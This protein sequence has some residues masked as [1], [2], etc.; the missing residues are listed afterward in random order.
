MKVTTAAGTW[1]LGND[2][3]AR[4]VTGGRQNANLRARI[5]KRDD[6]DNLTLLWDEAREDQNGKYSASYFHAVPVK[7]VR[8]LLGPDRD[9]ILA[10]L[11]EESLEE[12]LRRLEGSRNKLL[13][14]FGSLGSVMALIENGGTLDEIKK[15]LGDSMVYSIPE[16]ISASLRDTSY[17]AAGKI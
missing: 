10:N 4:D 16:D 5:D 3:I 12:K 8:E 15:A 6:G 13:A 1:E 11:G 9:T 14:L 2:N 7:I 17:Q